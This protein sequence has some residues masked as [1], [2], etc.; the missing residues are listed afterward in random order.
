MTLSRQPSSKSEICFFRKFALELCMTVYSH[1]SPQ[2]SK[3]DSL[4]QTRKHKEWNFRECLHGVL[5][6]LKSFIKEKVHSMGTRK[7]NINRFTRRV[8]GSFAPFLGTNNL[9]DSP[10]Y[11]LSAKA[12]SVGRMR[13]RIPE[14]LAIVRSLQDPG[15]ASDT[16]TNLHVYM[17]T[18]HSYLI[19]CRFL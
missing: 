13:L 18:A 2:C 17:L 19:Q 12:F 10:V 16:H 3:L 9:A 15:Y 7:V 5:R 4:Q 14:S 8:S 11:N 6:H 1:H